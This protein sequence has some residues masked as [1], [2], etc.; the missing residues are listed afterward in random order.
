MTPSNDL[1]I[2]HN[3][4]TDRNFTLLASE[5]RLFKR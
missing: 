3:D 2:D 4:G 5:S 1:A